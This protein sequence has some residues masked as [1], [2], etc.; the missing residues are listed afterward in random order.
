M[1]LFRLVNIFRDGNLGAALIFRIFSIRTE[2]SYKTHRS[3]DFTT[4]Q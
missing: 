2:I 3:V 4:K 1:Y